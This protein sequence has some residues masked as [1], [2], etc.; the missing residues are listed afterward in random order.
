MSYTVTKSA[1]I[2][3]FTLSTYSISTATNIPGSCGPIDYFINEAYQFVSVETMVEI[4]T[5]T[6]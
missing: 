5:I 6:V 4:G 1:V 3:P 2:Q